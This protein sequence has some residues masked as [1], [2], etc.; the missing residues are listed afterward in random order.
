MIPRFDVWM[1]T[2]NSE[3]LLPLILKRID[4]VIPAS[5]INKKFIVDDFSTD[6]TRQ[7]AEKLG[8]QVYKNEKKGLHNAQL[9]AFSLVETEY[10]ASFEHD[11]YLSEDWW[12]NIPL[13]VIEHG[14]DVA[15]GI[16]V[17]DAKGFRELDI[18]DN[19]HR[20]IFSE[21]NTFYAMYAV[22][23]L[24]RKCPLKRLVD[25]NVC[26]MHIR[27]NYSA[28]LKHSYFIY[29][30]VNS[31][32]IS[33]HAKCLVKSPLKSIQ[34]FRETKSYPVLAVYQL[35]RLMILTGALSN[36]LNKRGS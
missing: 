32:P 10:C 2:F 35:E 4:K 31:D 26:S 8:W 34:I 24:F 22:K 23:D 6:K 16:R 5:A 17:R 29:R 21:D 9:Q 28:C 36:Q 12:P 14:Y 3:K 20:D 11:V 7:T 18:Y 25:K 33:L 27:G 30:A 15:N 13:A 1:C 19:N